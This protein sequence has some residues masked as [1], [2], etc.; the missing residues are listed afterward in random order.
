[1]Y[2]NC[3]KIMGIQS[4]LTKKNILVMAVG[5][6]VFTILASQKGIIGQ[7]GSVPQKVAS[8]ISV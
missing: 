1:M 4:F 7:V 2:K 5:A 8:K 6:V 3:F